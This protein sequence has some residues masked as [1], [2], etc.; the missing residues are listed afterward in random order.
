MAEKK[1]DLAKIREQR[2]RRTNNE[3]A[4]WA[5]ANPEWVMAAIA[6]LAFK[7]GALRFGY[8]RDGGAYAIGIYFGGE[9]Y[10]EYVRPSENID[11]Y[12]SDLVRDF[13][14]DI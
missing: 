4:D 12:L 7:G 10:T 13:T 2:R 14:D 3:V 8:T 11:T 6:A 1:S 9:H 5:T